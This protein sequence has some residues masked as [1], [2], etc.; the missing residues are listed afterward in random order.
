MNDKHYS[1]QSDTRGTFTPRK[2]SL[3]PELP[4]TPCGVNS[5]SNAT[6]TILPVPLDRKDG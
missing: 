3:P 6:G 4:P 2:R 1:H 5:M